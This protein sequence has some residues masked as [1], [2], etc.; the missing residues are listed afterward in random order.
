MLQM[1][2]FDDK[3]ANYPDEQEILSNINPS[4]SED[5]DTNPLEWAVKSESLATIAYFV[6]KV[7]VKQYVV[8]LR[9]GIIR[10]NMP[11]VKF[12]LDKTIDKLDAAQLAEV[13]D[14]AIYYNR[15]DIVKLLA[16]KVDK[17]QLVKA[18][19]EAVSYNKIKIAKLL[20]GRV[21]AAQLVR[22]LKF[23][24]YMDNTVIIK[25]ITNRQKSLS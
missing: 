2:S 25:A 1:F 4:L 21:D 8:A 18:L 10:N 5:N 16:D 9:R 6:D 14:V 17:A 15:I 19:Y 11:V 12:I 13:L 20:I 3:V 24:I 22:V 23:A 7:G